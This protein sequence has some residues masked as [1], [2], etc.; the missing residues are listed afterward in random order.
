MMKGINAVPPTGWPAIPVEQIL[1]HALS[2]RPGFQ[3][4]TIHDDRQTGIVGHPVI[5][6]KREGFNTRC[7]G[8][9]LADAAMSHRQA[10]AGQHH[11][12]IAPVHAQPP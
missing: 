12:E 6:V 5:A 8:G 7:A 2:P 9:R 3:S 11:I 10:H 1:V 4:V